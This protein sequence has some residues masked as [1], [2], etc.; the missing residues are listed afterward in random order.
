MKASIYI[1]I[2]FCVKKCNYCDFASVADS[3]AAP[4]DY[5]ATVIKEM[6][7][8][9]KS[10]SEPSEAG[11]LYLGGG[12][13]SLLAP[14][15]V[16]K[17]MAAARRLYGL[18]ADAEVTLEA[19]PGTVT[20]ESLTCYRAAGVNR[21][22]IGV[23]SLDDR[24]LKLL[25]RVHTAEEAREAVRMA[26]KAGFNNLGIDLMHSL[27]GQT[28]AHWEQS[29]TDAMSLCPGHISAYGLT[30][31]NGTRFAAMTQ[32]GELSLPRDD[33]SARMYEVTIEMLRDAGFEHYE[34][35]NFAR[36]GYRSQHNQVYWHRGSYLG[37]GAAAHSFLRDPGY[38]QR[39][40]NPSDIGEYCRQVSLGNS[41]GE[42]GVVELSKYEAMGEAL[43]LGF[44]LLDGVD[45][46]GFRDE[47][48]ESLSEAFPGVVQR[49]LANGLLVEHHNRLCL[50][51]KGVLLANQLFAE[52]V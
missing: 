45:L 30:I 36:P 33:D 9:A 19:N 4:P 15:L 2:P 10:L 43:F 40:Q 37:F 34:I 49:H 3:P 42:G 14:E 28:L 12:T 44:R 52:F 6:E 27:P 17:I 51:G 13:P 32:A 35:A 11:T 1:H 38:G 24:M 23:Q 26:Q 31:E 48:G 21:L 20:L 22:S 47:F 46:A 7:L 8:R 41:P 18:V 25:G 39:F 5:V 50:T 16:E 29:L